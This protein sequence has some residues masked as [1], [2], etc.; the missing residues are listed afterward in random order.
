MLLLILEPMDTKARV[1]V[2]REVQL[3]LQLTIGWTSQ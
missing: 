1:E 3:Q 2:V